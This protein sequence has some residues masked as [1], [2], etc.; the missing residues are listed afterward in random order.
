MTRSA[1]IELIDDTRRRHGWN[2]ASIAR[3][4]SNRG[5]KLTRQDIGN[6][7]A[8]EGMTRP[9]PD[10]MRAL[11]AGLQLPPYR[12][13]LAVL[14]DMGIEVPLEVRTVEDAIEHDHTLS[15]HARAQL[16]ALLQ[17]ERAR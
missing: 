8:A 9:S 12:V 10:K 2:D 13:A 1:L 7:R 15:P 16:L 5:H 3:D 17:L 11:A 6:W 14:A 4:A